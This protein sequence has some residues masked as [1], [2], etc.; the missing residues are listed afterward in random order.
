MKQIE[1]KFDATIYHKIE[2]EMKKNVSP[3]E[4]NFIL[5]SLLYEIAVAEPMTMVRQPV[6]EFLITMKKN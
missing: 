3:I 5:N 1:P 4:F 2:V 6:Y